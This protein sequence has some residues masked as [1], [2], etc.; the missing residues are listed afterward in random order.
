M[1]RIFK[2]FICM[3]NIR[4][5]VKEEL[6]KT[7]QMDNI[8]FDSSNPFDNHPFFGNP[9]KM[10]NYAMEQAEKFDKLRHFH[11]LVGNTLWGI[12]SPEEKMEELKNL[13]KEYLKV[14]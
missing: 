3:K 2:L 10:Y 14:Y 1:K 7:L 11:Q 4:E 13:Y 12:N 8:L 9:E 5:I 6:E